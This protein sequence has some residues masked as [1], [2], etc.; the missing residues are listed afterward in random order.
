MEGFYRTHLFAECHKCGRGGLICQDDYASLKSGYWWQWRNDSYKHRYEDFIKTLLTSSPALDDVS[1][2]YPYAIPTPYM[3]QVEESCK[4]GLDSPCGDGYEGPL[5]AV[6]SSRYY[7]EFQSC[8][9]CPSRTWIAGQL[10][11]IASILLVIFI[12]LAWK[13]K[14][15]SKSVREFNVMDTFL[16]KVKIIIGFYQVTHG[17][18]EVFSYI[19]WPDSLK[20]VAK[21]SAI[22]QINVLQIVPI[23]CL[24]PEFHVNAFGHLFL[25]LAINFTV[26]G[27]AGV[28]YGVRKVTILRNKS[29]D[30]EEKSTKLSQT[31]ELVYRNVFFFLYVTYLST[32]SKTASVLPFACRR[33]CRDKDEEVCNEFLKED[34][35]IQCQGSAYNHL[36]IVA[37]I[38]T[39]YIL[40]LPTVSFIVLWRHR[41]ATLS[42]SDGDIGSGGEVVAGLRFLF[43]NY[44]P[45][46]WYW[47]LVEMSRKVII[48][49]GLI[50]VGQESR[51][52]IGL[53]WIIAGMYG[54]VFA[55]FKPLQDTFENRL[56]STSLAVT[57]VNL[58]IGAVSRIPAEN[59]SDAV[60]RHTDA[61]AM[62]I[63]ILGANTLVIGLLVG[64]IIYL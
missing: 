27:G 33:L 55:W 8:T 19:K 25:L 36:L 5:C 43:E 61:V 64:K 31:K 51:S 22:L 52:F 54:M 21:Y 47:E 46:S 24:F 32:F 11:I 26:I 62:K 34:Y 41:R 40:A 28:I 17:L 59:I 37:Y 18:L 12:F 38:S 45:H 29:M 13:S 63:L 7:K 49:S 53:A 60:D 20:D 9:K 23:H 15:N 56:M 1:V 10:S 50:L 4:G 57:V 42:T 6:C 16:S 48:T 30:V 58:G 44:K 39:A 14:T 3:C 2:Q 35:S